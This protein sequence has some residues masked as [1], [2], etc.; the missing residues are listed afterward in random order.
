MFITTN[1]PQ[2]NMRKYKHL[3]IAILLM[4]ATLV[5]CLGETEEFD[6]SELEQQIV[7]LQ[8]DQEK[9][10]QT[11]NEQTQANL[12]LQQTLVEMNQSNTQEFQQLLDYIP[13]IQSNISA[14]QATIDLIITE[15]EESNSTDA[16]LLALLNSTQLSLS[17]LEEDLDDTTN[18]LIMKINSRAYYYRVNWSFLDLSGLG[19]TGPLSLYAA[20]LSYTNL[21]SV[22]LS[23]SF[24]VLANLSNSYL[25]YANL[26]GSDLQS[27]DLSNSY[28]GDANLFG[29]DL[30]NAILVGIYWSNTICPDGT[31]SDDNG[32]TC[33]NN[34]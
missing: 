30:T 16:E 27:A 1:I 31:N 22:D 8:E 24:L 23:N 11:I 32:G 7:D 28:M 6:I 14:S 9:M 4:S 2:W 13:I 10:N 12:V 34:L 26:S 29:A 25:I 15:L 19:L 3:M 20:N 17:D 33:E 21:N 18:E 5:G